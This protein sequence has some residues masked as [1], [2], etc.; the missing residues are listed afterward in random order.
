MMRRPFSAAI[1]A[2]VANSTRPANLT[3]IQF[4]TV[5]RLKSPNLPRRCQRCNKCEESEGTHDASSV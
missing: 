4:F 5:A 3:T 1:V 2:F